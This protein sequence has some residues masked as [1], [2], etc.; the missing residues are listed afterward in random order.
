MGFCHF[1]TFCSRYE[2]ERIVE[3]EKKISKG[4]DCLKEEARFLARDKRVKREQLCQS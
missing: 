2:E 4:R 1:L 3:L